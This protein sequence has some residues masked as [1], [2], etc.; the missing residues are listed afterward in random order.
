MMRYLLAMA[1]LL[2]AQCAAAADAA[3]PLLRGSYARLVQAHS[4]KPFVVA[5]W[6]VSCTHCGKDLEIFSRLL[7]QYPQFELILISTDAPEQSDEIAGI[8]AGYRLPIAITAGGGKAE[9]WVFADGYT[10]R[11]R[12]EVDAQ[13]YGELPRTYFYDATGKARGVSGVLDEQETGA[14][15]QR[16]H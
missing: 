15:V 11:L 2:A 3:Q 13:W 12:H 4:G 16:A 6:S 1:L 9:S 5:L 14:W 10:E 7:R 8:L